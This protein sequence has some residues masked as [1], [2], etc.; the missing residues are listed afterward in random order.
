[1]PAHLQARLKHGRLSSQPHMVSFLLTYRSSEE[2]HSAFVKC[3]S[4]TLIAS[5]RKRYLNLPISERI[6]RGEAPGITTQKGVSRH[7]PI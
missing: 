1:M 2:D 7:G 5:H 3:D 6:T 4:P